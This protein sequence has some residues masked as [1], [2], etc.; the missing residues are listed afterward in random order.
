MSN[1]YRPSTRP[2][3]DGIRTGMLLENCC[4]ITGSAAS[5]ALP[6]CPPPPAPRPPPPAPRPPPFQ[7][8]A[9][10][11]RLSSSCFLMLKGFFHKATHP[12]PS[13]PLR[14][15]TA[16]LQA[17]T[18]KP[19][20]SLPA[21]T[22]VHELCVAAAAKRLLVCSTPHDTSL[23]FASAAAISTQSPRKKRRWALVTFAGFKYP[24]AFKICYRNPQAFKIC[25]L[26]DACAAAWCFLRMRILRNGLQ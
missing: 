12:P 17:K 6:R 23:F 7:N 26:T 3:A 18:F 13:R 19:K 11:C 10:C 8:E 20:K 9:R 22:K 4:L 16:L 24:Q 25:Y 21:G 1:S 2:P 14:N 5:A 15:L